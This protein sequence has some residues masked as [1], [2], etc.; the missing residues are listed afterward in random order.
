MRNAI[1]LMAAV[2]LAASADARPPRQD[3]YQLSEAETREA[4]ESYAKC[5]VKAAPQLASTAVVED[6]D[7]KLLI[8]TGSKL[9]SPDCTRAAGFIRSLR[10]EANI[11]RALLAETLIK[12]DPAVAVAA[13]AL[14]GMPTLAYRQPWPVETVDAKGKPLDA[15]AI[16]RQQQGYDRRVGAIAGQQ[17][18]ECVVRANPAGVRSVYDTKSGSAEEL[19]ALKALAPVLPGCVPANKKFSFD[20]ASLRGSLALA[21]YRL[22]MA[23]KGVTWAGEP[24]KGDGAQN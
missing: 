3:A 21:Y 11:Y 22:A 19:A 13:D 4:M 24:A 9:V 15:E 2:G 12:R 8:G 18:G 16:A 23:S 14:K 10:F 17:I 7:R 5:S 20:R 6:W 1:F